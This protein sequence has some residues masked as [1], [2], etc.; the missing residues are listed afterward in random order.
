MLQAT[1]N[2]QTLAQSKGRVYFSKDGQWL[3]RRRV[4]NLKRNNWYFDYEQPAHLSK[5]A[6]HFAALFW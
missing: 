4:A 1:C 5:S 2:T 3:E 6:I